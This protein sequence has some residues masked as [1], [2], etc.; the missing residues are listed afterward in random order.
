M[1]QHRLRRHG[2]AGHC[3]DLL[4]HRCLPCITGDLYRTKFAGHTQTQCAQFDADHSRTRFL[5][6]LPNDLARLAQTKHGR[7]LADA[8]GGLVHVVEHNRADLEKNM[9]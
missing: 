2:F 3:L 6:Q 9:Q 8:D 7:R 1:L 5:C 4:L